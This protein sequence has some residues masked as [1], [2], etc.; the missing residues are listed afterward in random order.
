MQGTPK[1]DLWKIPRER[2]LVRLNIGRE[3]THRPEPAVYPA[4]HNYD[5]IISH[6]A[7]FDYLSSSGPS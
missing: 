6:I 7:V 5:V 4:R 1:E 2:L 3:H